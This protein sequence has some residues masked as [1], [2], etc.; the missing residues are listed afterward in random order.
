MEAEK[1]YKGKGGEIMRGGVCH[2]IYAMSTA[3]I[4]IDDNISMMLFKTLVENF[5]HS[6]Q[7]I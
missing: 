1:L 5:K 2:L 7:E 3:K 6:T 4:A